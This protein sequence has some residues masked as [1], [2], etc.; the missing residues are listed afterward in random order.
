[1]PGCRMLN[2]ALKKAPAAR[3]AASVSANRAATC[4]R[5]APRPGDLAVLEQRDFVPAPVVA[6][7]AGQA[8]RQ[9][10]GL[11]HD[12]RVG[13]PRKLDREL[14]PKRRRATRE[15]LQPGQRARGPQ[16]PRR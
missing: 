8:P 1:M 4:A 10:L 15:P 5:Q 11:P 9:A 12:Q 16:R 7:G 3:T 13:A 14:A 2:L 6:R